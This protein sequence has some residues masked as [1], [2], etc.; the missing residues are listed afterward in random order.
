MLLAAPLHTQAFP[1]K[2]MLDML[3]T[4]LSETSDA[5]PNAA[6]IP[7]ATLKI[8]GEKISLSF[9]INAVERVAVPVPLATAAWT[10]M[11]VSV[12]G[13]PATALRRMDGSLW[14]PIEKGVHEIAVAGLLTSPNEWE[15]QSILS[16]RRVIVE[17]A[18]WDVSGVNPDGVVEGRALFSPKEKAAVS[19]SAVVYDQPNLAA[20]LRVNRTIEMGLVW[21]VHTTVTR[22][23]ANRQ[24]V[25]VRLPLLPGEQVTSTDANIGNNF[26]SVRLGADDREFAWTSE[27]TQSEILTLATPENATWS[28]QWTLAVS[29]IWNIALSG[30]SP[31]FLQQPELV[32]VW[33][34]WPGEAVEIAVSRPRAVEGPNVTVN[35]VQQDVRLGNRRRTVTLDIALT[36]SVG[37]D[38]LLTL[39]PNA[40]VTNLTLNGKPMPVRKTG[41]DHVVPIS[42]GESRI[43]V[44]WKQNVALGIRS[45]VCPVTLSS[46]AA[47]IRTT[48]FIPEHRGKFSRWILAAFGPQQG[49]AVRIWGI[50]IGVLVASFVLARLPNSPLRSY[51]WLL[52]GVGLTQASLISALIV[53]GWLFFLRWRGSETF[54][55]LSRRN[56]N[57]LQI[58]LALMTITVICILLSAVS[59]GLL[60]GPQMFIEGEG[61]GAGSLRWYTPQSG[62][63]LPSPMVV[64]VSIWWY[65]FAMLAWALWLATALL[66]WLVQGWKQFSTAG[67]WKKA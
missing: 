63:T 33:S 32:P 29:P 67:L 20:V 45:S 53:I 7:V 10:P 1:D 26:I 44:E 51:E 60:G 5:F 2:D 23:T 4:R 30:L 28:E 49:P 66:R 35:S 14:L 27:L 52:L 38:Y 64:T 59:S 54:T 31:V 16:P 41:N 17:A 12:N 36:A 9:T 24:P 21:Q 58:V 57:L 50:L 3:R 56:F 42:P 6:E 55:K 48:I 46:E 39:P 19:S 13:E 22:I 62:A 61:S 34:P 15:W 47:N 37:Q 8:D 11:A 43:K 65:R 25:S 18:E 40:E